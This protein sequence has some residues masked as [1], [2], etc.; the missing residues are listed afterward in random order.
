[1]NLMPRFFWV[2]ITLL[3]GAA[4]WVLGEFGEYIKNATERL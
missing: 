1:M 2:K 3:K 4:A